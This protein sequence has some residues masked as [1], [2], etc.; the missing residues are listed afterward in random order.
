MR[1]YCNW[2]NLWTVLGM[3][4]LTT[5][6]AQNTTYLLTPQKP[7]VEDSVSD[8]VR[9]LVV[10]PVAGALNISFTDDLNNRVVG[11]LFVDAPQS[12]SG[13]ISGGSLFLSVPILLTVRPALSGAKRI[14]LIL[15]K[16]ISP[17]KEKEMFS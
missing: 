10:T 1:R 9:D 16:N 14:V 3:L 6:W 12:V 15:E 8:R 2:I 4:C 5:A 11:S 13:R 7:I 17:R